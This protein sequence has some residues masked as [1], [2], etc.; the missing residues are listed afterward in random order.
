MDDSLALVESIADGMPV[1][2]YAVDEDKDITL[3]DIFGVTPNDSPKTFGDSF[4]PLGDDTATEEGRK[5][6]TEEFISEINKL[7]GNTVEVSDIPAI[8]ATIQ[9]RTGLT[10]DIEKFIHETVMQTVNTLAE[11][12]KTELNPDGAVSEMAKETAGTANDAVAVPSAEVGPLPEV[13]PVAETPE[14][15]LDTNPDD[16]AIPTVDDGLMDLSDIGIE[17][18]DLA[19]A[20]DDNATDAVPSDDDLSN[21][22][23]GLDK[24]DDSL[25]GDEE[26][27]GEA[28]GT[29]ELPA[30]D[31]GDKPTDTE[32]AAGEPVEPAAE[33][34]AG[35]PV[36]PVAETD[37][38]EPAPADEPSGSE[39]PA[40]EDAAKTEAVSE[41]LLAILESELDKIHADYVAKS[42]RAEFVRNIGAI[43]E[44]RSKELKGKVAMTEARAERQK[45]LDAIIEG[46]QK[47]VDRKAMIESAARKMIADRKAAVAKRDAMVESIV[48][49]AKSGMEKV[50]MMESASAKRAHAA[51][52]TSK[53]VDAKLDA[54]VESVRTKSVDAKL[55]AIVE[56]VTA[57]AGTKTADAKA[58]RA[59]LIESIVDASAQERINKIRDRVK[60][61]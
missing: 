34:T 24:L 13:E 32:T 49:D 10:G 23:D 59:A 36:E 47:R 2:D 22:G 55:D 54:I 53:D 19:A 30:S 8:A 52:K 27:T 57:K 41:E 46:V 11:Q 44:A 42:E 20:S 40:E 7:P 1:D 3:D 51:A 26:P 17:D 21:L 14:P 15:A 43:L 38:K 28:A 25:F 18:D 33:T 5:Q 56:S 48:A 12:N 4:A 31:E 9:M 29:D 39:E 61:V 45:K 37:A 6:I 58:K 16:A 60:S 35:E 50:A